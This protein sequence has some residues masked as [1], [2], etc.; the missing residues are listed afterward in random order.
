MQ[1]AIKMVA[2]KAVQNAI[3]RIIVPENAKNH[4][5]KATRKAAIY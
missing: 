5:G 3:V 1:I 2:Q 4:I